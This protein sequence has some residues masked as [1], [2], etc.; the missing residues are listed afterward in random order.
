MHGLQELIHGCLPDDKPPRLAKGL[1]GALGIVKP[2]CAD[3]GGIELKFVEPLREVVKTCGYAVVL[4]PGREQERCTVAAIGEIIVDRLWQ[5]KV[6]RSAGETP[7]SQQ[8]I[9]LAT[10]CQGKLEQLLARLGE[11]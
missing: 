7:G 9:P 11:W 5:E 8:E 4:L 10:G 3:P 1:M 6:H 2:E